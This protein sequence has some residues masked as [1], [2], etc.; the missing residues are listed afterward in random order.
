MRTDQDIPTAEYGNDSISGDSSE[1]LIDTD[2]TV[3]AEK[4]SQ[5][6]DDGDEATCLNCGFKTI[7]LSACH[8]KC[9]NC[10]VEKDCSETSIW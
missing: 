8:R 5:V 1:I 4:E 9:P 7:S 6:V 10:G 3:A 2:K